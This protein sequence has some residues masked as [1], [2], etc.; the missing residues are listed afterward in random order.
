[1][2]GHCLTIYQLF[3]VQV[4]MLES[5][6]CQVGALKEWSESLNPGIYVPVNFSLNYIWFF[7][8]VFLGWKALCKLEWSAG[9]HSYWLISIIHWET[10]AGG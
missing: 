6:E 5:A 4:L 2:P 8:N 3:N 7:P 9:M 1:M 10:E